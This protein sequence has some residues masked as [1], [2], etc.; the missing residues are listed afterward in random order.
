LND[1][2]Q[3]ILN[4]NPSVLP[5][6]T[7]KIKVSAYDVTEKPSLTSAEIEIRVDH[8][9][10][11][12][13]LS[14]T[15]TEQATLG[16]ERPSYK[17]L[18]KA[19]DGVAGSTN[20]NE[21]RSGAAS[22]VFKNDG[23]VVGEYKPGCPTQSCE[24]IQELEVPAWELTPGEHTLAITATDAA[25]HTSKPKEFKYA[26]GDH[27]S[28]TLDV[29]GMPTEA[30]GVPW[31]ASYQDTFGSYGSG[32]GQLSHPADAVVDRD[33][34]LW[35]IDKGN[36]RVQKFNAKG[37]YLS[38]F[39]SYGS[40]NGQFNSPNAIDVDP[41]GN[42]WVTDS[43]NHRV[44]KFNA[45]GEY[46]SKFGSYGS[47]N[48]QFNAPAGIVASPDGS[49]I[50]VAD[51]GNHRIELFAKN[52]AYWGQ[53]GSYGW[54]DAQFDEPTGLAL[55]GPW[56]E[57]NFT[58]LVL[59]SGNNRVQRFTP[60]GT[61]I[62]KFGTY[63][64]GNGQLNS[65]GAINTDSAGNVWIGDRNNGRVEGFTQDGEYLTQFGSLGTGAGQFKFIYPMG[66]AGNPNGNLW[67]T[68]AGNNRLQ[69]WTIPKSTVSEFLEPIS[70]AAT[71][72]GFGVSSLEVRLTN[73]AQ[74]T[75]V[76]ARHTQSCLKGVA[77]PLALELEGVDLSEKPSGTYTLSVVATDTA[78]NERRKARAFY[79][80][81]A[82]PE[83][84]LDGPLADSAG[85]PLN[86][87]VA[88]LEVSAGDADPAS[89][90]VQT[91]RV[92]RDNQLMATYRPD[93]S[94]S[95]HDVDFSYPYHPVEDGA[96]RHLVPVATT[97]EGSIG[98]LQRIS[99]PSANDCWA[100]GR[101]KYSKTELAEGKTQAPLLE[102]WNGSEWQAVAVPK[103]STA[104][105]A[106]LDGVYCYSTT[107]CRA[108][109]RYYNGTA[110][111]PLVELW[112]GAKWTSLATPVPSGFSEASL[113]GF[114]CSAA[115]D[116]G[117]WSYGRTTVTP[118]E[119][120]E[121][122][123]PMSF[124]Q[125]WTGT[126]WQTVTA[127]KPSGASD[128]FLEGLDCRSATFCRAVG[129]SYNGSINQPLLESWNGSQWTVSSLPLPAGATGGYLHGISCAS[130]NSCWAHGRTQ[131]TAAQQTEGKTT[132]PFFERWNGSGWTI[133][134]VPAPPDATTVGIAGVS[135]SSETACTAVGQYENGWSE[136]LPLAQTWDGSSW[137]FQPVP[138]WG[139]ATTSALLGV[140]CAAANQCSMVG[141]AE[142]DAEKRAAM[143]EVESPRHEPH[144]ITVEAVDS[145]GN[146]SSRMIEVD[147]PEH[148]AQTPK[149]NSEPTSLA[150]KAV[151]SPG[152][153][154]SGFENSVPAAIAPSVETTDETSEALIDPS[155]SQ[156]Q[157]DLEAVDTFAEG[158]TAVTQAE[159]FELTD[160]ACVTP[161]QTTSAATNATVANG[162]SAV[163]A[164]TAP[165]T[166]TV[167]RPTAGGTTL[168]ESLRG[169]NA[170]SSFSWTVTISSSQEL[171]EL[172]SGAVA[173]VGPPAGEGGD[174]FTVQKPQG[175]ETP[176]VLKDAQLQLET[177]Q[178][179]LTAAQA[180]T[181]KEVVAVIAK[182]WVVLSQGV[183]VPAKIEV[184]PVVYTPI[185]W[186]VEVFIPK[187]QLEAQVW[188]VGL[189][190]EFLSSL[191]AN[192]HCS[193]YA[194][195]PCGSPDL[196]RAANYAKYW[197]NEDHNDA[198]NNKYWDYGSN[199]CTNFISQIL[200]AA[201]MRFMRFG[202]HG[203]GSWW[204]NSYIPIVG[205]PKY[206]DTES[207]K[208][209]DE[210]PRHLWRFGLARLDT[211]QQPGGW[212]RGDIIAMDWLGTNGKGD[213]NHLMFVVGTRDN[214][215]QREPMLANHSTLSYGSRPWE[216]VKD[217]IE[218]TEGSN[219]TRFALAV[220]HTN[221]NLDH[222]VH[223]P[224]NLYGPDGLF[225]G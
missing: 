175:A 26:T 72:S 112:D 217:R 40:A 82:P 202:A 7:R 106:F 144:Q 118:A 221:A 166:D 201:G 140:A 63:G 206:D 216:F 117:C 95:C 194:E 58:V 168:V 101:T 31:G 34:N 91:I 15:L 18:A 164:N 54:E 94:S 74:S 116:P 142:I 93:C 213:I 53:K 189:A 180:E 80:D 85:Q 59:D 207:W 65:P 119:Q 158:E 48:G 51:R 79:L 102:R 104:T 137:R 183:V 154:V 110:N 27:Q 125:R 68:D 167:I 147:V 24:V 148:V 46:L 159:G 174:V 36:H 99:C 4:Y 69:R 120:A 135:C 173:I 152:Q 90:G 56:G 113:R 184:A 49:L 196:D 193:I 177:S 220:K 191:A 8:A 45:K 14:G 195:S 179:E 12:I 150:P 171:V 145:Q 86:S 215:G 25:G 169:P 73:A 132:T 77:C 204:V 170:P 44:Q 176:K 139:E 81:S 61:F 29:T 17:I 20:P 28:P 223:A 130:A 78:G 209:A 141:Y 178:Y 21:I 205:P 67:V 155:Y 190:V 134:S 32:N 172:P 200:R 5:E 208:L 153:A 70:A 107:F 187:A 92:E 87:A 185:E 43:G 151:L 35:V 211:S 64:S 160:V 96:D 210:L 181:T 22:L 188:P 108:V 224:E 212:T 6:G 88:D 41:E 162:D 111:R 182:P 197:G 52:G 219:W 133:A 2:S 161:N 124:F 13:T 55:G 9:A 33:G 198:R 214:H 100:V 114:S 146:A 115:S 121:G 225:H 203:D 47:A 136:T 89:V 222:K 98:E 199:D 75:E 76:L 39:G 105:D 38:K 122:K 19:K 37:E 71:D 123:T 157:P 23:Q 163:F 149:C 60:F 30:P 109:G 50:Y 11:T 131:L 129:Y 1:S 42:I 143:A 10:P 3:P 156:P 218:Q 126:A 84:E 83:I 192:G 127:P 57:F 128:V 138:G 16:T 97:G 103:P 62:G 66:I 165:E 186:E